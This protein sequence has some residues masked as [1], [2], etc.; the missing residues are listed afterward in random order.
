MELDKKKYKREEV[1]NL[2]STVQ[3][4]YEEKISSFKLRI[5]DLVRDN[6]SLQAELQSY[7]ENDEKVSS[8]IKDAEDFS[9]MLKNKAKEQYQAEVELLKSFSMRWREFFVALKEKYPLYAKTDSAKKVYDDISK[10]ISSKTESDAISLCNQ[11]LGDN[12]APFN[13][14]GK[15]N[16][17][18][19][20]TSDNGFNLDE[21]LNPGELE[22]EELCR[23]LGLLD[24][25]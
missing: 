11:A 5:N 16:D 24:E 22:L 8:A 13:P 17:Y 3:S 9:V 20:A 1:E 14:K 7:K 23:E 10:I 18:I 4:K 12:D 15:I 21:V 2:I 19:A 6:K 25:N